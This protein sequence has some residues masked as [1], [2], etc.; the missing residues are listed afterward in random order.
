MLIKQIRRVARDPALDSIK[1]D[2][3]NVTAIDSKVSNVSRPSNLDKSKNDPENL[4]ID[5]MLHRIRWMNEPSIVPLIDPSFGYVPVSSPPQP[6]YTWNQPPVVSQVK[7]WPAMPEPPTIQTDG[8]TMRLQLPLQ[9]LSQLPVFIDQQLRSSA[10]QQAVQ[11]LLARQ[12]AA[13]RR[14]SDKPEIAEQRWKR[15]VRQMATSVGVKSSADRKWSRLARMD[16]QT[17]Q[18]VITRILGGFVGDLV[19]VVVEEVL[20]KK[21]EIIANGIRLMVGDLATFVLSKGNLALE[22]TLK[23]LTKML[24]MRS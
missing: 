18:E 15:F 11:S 17:L 16:A 21:G 6:V 20:Q 9:Q 19:G 23:N 13:I 22:L 2:T 4:T 7:F 8:Q 24:F 3:S 1:L 5:S 10:G 14:S 12:W